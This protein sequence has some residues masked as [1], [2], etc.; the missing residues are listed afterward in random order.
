MGVFHRYISVIT[1][2]YLGVV[3]PPHQMSF[4]GYIPGKFTNF[5]SLIS[6]QWEKHVLVTECDFLTSLFLEICRD[7]RQR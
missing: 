3:F 1:I 5:T 2:S 7:S 6:H 4:T